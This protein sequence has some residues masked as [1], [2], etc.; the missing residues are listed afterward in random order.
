MKSVHYLGLMSGLSLACGSEADEANPGPIT[1]SSA[2][3]LVDS[4]PQTDPIVNGVKPDEQSK[5]SGTRDDFNRMSSEWDPELNPATDSYVEPADFVV[6]AAMTPLMM[7][8]M[9]DGV[10][11]FSAMSLQSK[12]SEIRTQV[13]A[14]RAAQIDYFAVH[15][16]Y[17]AVDDFEPDAQPGAHLRSLP[18]ESGFTAL[19]WLPADLR[20]SYKVVIDDPRDFRVIGISDLDEDGERAS[21]TATKSIQATLNSNEDIY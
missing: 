18:A 14:I 10:A 16:R 5:L 19:G 20:G 3:V 12:R 4:E 8:A 7:L 15:G 6:G 21:F 2:D 9:H 1:P 17:L 13:A 11:Q